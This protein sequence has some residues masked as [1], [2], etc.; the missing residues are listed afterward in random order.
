M[1]KTAEELAVAIIRSGRSFQEAAEVVHLPVDQVVKIWEREMSD[2]KAGT[3]ENA[4][5]NSSH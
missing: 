4:P 5:K 1:A 3:P 2:H